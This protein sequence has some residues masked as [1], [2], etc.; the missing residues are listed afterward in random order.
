M[1]TSTVRRVRRESHGRGSSVSEVARLQSSPAQGPAESVTGRQR[2]GAAR[3]AN[4]PVCCESCEKCNPGG[5]YCGL[6]SPFYRVPP[7]KH[8]PRVTVTSGGPFLLRGHLIRFRHATSAASSSQGG[9]PLPM[10]DAARQVHATNRCIRPTARSP[11]QSPPKSVQARYFFFASAGFASGV[12]VELC[13]S[14]VPVAIVKVTAS[15]GITT[16]SSVPGRIVSP[17]P[18]LASAET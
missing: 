13:S 12:G 14:G 18:I 11:A 7:V 15:P 10:S 9:K 3:S 8:L 16:T 17:S 5:L 1:K 2:K 6:L 4:P